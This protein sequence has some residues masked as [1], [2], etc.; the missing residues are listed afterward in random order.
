MVYNAP[1]AS[2]E[3]L[4]KTRSGKYLL[5]IGAE[6]SEFTPGEIAVSRLGGNIPALWSST[7]ENPSTTLLFR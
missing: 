5:E 2:T 3:Y 4:A 6:D 7:Q 1:T